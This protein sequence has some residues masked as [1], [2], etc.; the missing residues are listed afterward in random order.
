MGDLTP[1][2][3]FVMFLSIAVL[4]GTAHVLGEL[5]QRFRQPAVLGELVAGVLLGPSVL[6]TLFPTVQV[7]LFPL[8]GANAFV[9]NAL[10]TIAVVL[11]LLVAGMEVDLSII[12]KQGQTVMKVGVGRLSC[13]F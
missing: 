5:A 11:F 10:A 3:I 13:H 4:L 1:H 7:F 6:G 8:E 12:W 9:L 2:N